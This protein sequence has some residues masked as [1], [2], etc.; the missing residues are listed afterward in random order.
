MQFEIRIDPERLNRHIRELAQVGTLPE[1]GISRLALTD[2][3]KAGRDLFV[4]WL[5]ELSLEVRIDQVGNIIGFQPGRGDAR[6]VLIGSHLDTVRAAGPLDGAL[7]VLAGLEILQTLQEQGI[8]TQRTVAVVTFTNEEGARFTTDMMGSRAFCGELSVEEAWDV[9]DFE[10]ACVGDELRRI[11]YAGDF[12][13]GQVK[14][15]AY[16]ELHIEQGPILDKEQVTIGAVEAI[17][18]IS[19]QELTITG[20]ANHAGTTPLDARRDAGLAAAKVIQYL[21][22]LAKGLPDQRATCGRLSFLPDVIN[23]IPGEATLTV[24]LRNGD[25]TVLKKAEQQ[26]AEYLASLVEQENVEISSRMLARVSPSRCDPSVVALIEESARGLGLAHRRMVSGAGHDAQI[27][28]RTCPTA[29]IFIPSKDGISHSL[30]EYSRP[31]DIE[32]GANVLLH[33]ALR[34]ADEGMG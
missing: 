31:E 24:D 8:H 16:L 19:W 32:A 15:S 1:G 6:P 9:S 30:A 3:D 34:L 20:A 22:E 13:C 17:T 26:L 25:D 27:V 10:G 2:A 4:S 14:P 18:G 12:P 11:G 23:V 28:A 5:E 7:G 33:T 21:R 29:M